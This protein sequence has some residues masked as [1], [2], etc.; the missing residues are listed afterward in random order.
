M[1]S[2]VTIS[3][4]DELLARLDAEATDLG[5][6]RSELVRESLATYLG[7]T[8]DE[9]IDDARRARMLEALE[10][11]RNFHVGRE[12]RD[13]RPSLEILREVRETD[14][15]APMRDARKGKR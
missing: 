11:M 6:A 8:R 13:D 2:K 3:L 10:G 14:D 4:P 9:R 15:S 1:T 5:V 7:R 12:V